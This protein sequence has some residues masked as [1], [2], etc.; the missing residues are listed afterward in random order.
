MIGKKVEQVIDEKK[1]IEEIKAWERDIYDNEYD[2]KKFDFVFERIYEILEEQP[3]CICSRREWYQKGY[4]DGLN[5]DKWIPCSERLPSEDGKYIM[6]TTKGS[7]YCA[8]YSKDKS[9]NYGF[10]TDSYTHIEAWQPLPIPYKKE[11]A[12]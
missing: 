2:A 8:K 9:T 1:L 6:C 3:Q 11:G 10:H 5:A 4:Q 7:V 12:E